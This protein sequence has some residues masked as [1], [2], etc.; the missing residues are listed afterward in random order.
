MVYAEALWNKVLRCNRVFDEY[1]LQGIIIESFV[2][3]DL[4]QHALVLWVE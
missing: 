2:G 4:L 3:I 1:V